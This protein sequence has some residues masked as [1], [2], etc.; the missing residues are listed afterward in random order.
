MVPRFSGRRYPRQWPGR[1]SVWRQCGKRRRRKNNKL[2]RS[3]ARARRAW[4]PSRC[5]SG[6]SGSCCPTLPPAVALGHHAPV[7]DAIE[8][9]REKQLSCVLVVEHGQLVGVLTE[10][11]VVTKVAATPLDVDHV[12]L[13]EVMQPDPESLHLDDALVYAFHQM[14][15]GAYRHVPVVDEQRRPTALVSMQAIIDELVAAFPQELLN[16]PPSP[17]HAIAPTPEGA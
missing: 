2:C 11:D 9:M 4:P 10:R 3:G 15:R 17:A 13:R 5:C 6:R 7:R 12:P 16:L 1:R 8:V 14:H